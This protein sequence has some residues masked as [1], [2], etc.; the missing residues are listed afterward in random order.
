MQGWTVRVSEQR[1]GFSAF[2]GG[3]PQTASAVHDGQLW[4]RKRQHGRASWVRWCCWRR[5][6]P[7]G[8]RS[9]IAT[10]AGGEIALWQQ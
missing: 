9:V 6:G 4:L 1:L 2:V 3:M 8:W 5:E 7:A 10:P